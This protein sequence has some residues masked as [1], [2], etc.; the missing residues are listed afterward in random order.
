MRVSLVMV[1]GGAGGLQQSIVPYAVALREFGHDVQLIMNAASPLLAEVRSRGFSPDLVRGMRRRPMTSF[2]GVWRS[3]RA[4]APDVIIG[5]ASK[6]YPVAKAA[7]RKGI[8]V[9]SRLGSM[10]NKKIDAL[11]G[12]SAILATSNEMRER[13]ISRGQ[14]ASRVRVV[15]NFL[16]DELQPRPQAEPNRLRMGSMGR[17]VP[18]KG[19]DALLSAA[20]ILKD[21]G[22]EFD[23]SIAGAGTEGEAL[24]DLARRLDIQVDWPGWVHGAD[25]TAFLNSL[26]IFVCPSREEPFGQIYLDAMRFHLPVVTTDTVGARA[27]FTPGK[28]CRMCK[29]DD[30][31]ALA[32]EISLLL[33]DRSLRREI[34][35]AG[36]ANFASTFQMRGAGRTLCETL[37]E[38]VKHPS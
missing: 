9:V 36:A 5:F 22:H 30:P 18:R 12:A 24:R 38:L 37:E 33:N 1:T 8:P 13:V 10:D 20:R 32:D 34:G 31:Q 2:F 7:A 27:I 11:L 15:P 6:G 29:P 17:F 3:L 25:K 16:I 26:D 4:F 23:L 19:F 35:D 14:P 28:D 21:R